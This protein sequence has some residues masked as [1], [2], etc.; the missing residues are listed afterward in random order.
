MRLDPITL[1]VINNRIREIVS[2]MEHLLFHGGYST[3]LRESFDGSAGICDREGLVVMG[4]GMPLHLFPYHYSVRAVLANY[5][6]QEMEDGD[7]FILTDPYRGGNLHLP[8]LVIITPIFVDGDVLGFGVSIA[9]KTDL[10]GIVPG[11]SGAASRE[12]FHEGLLL[13]GVKY[14]TKDGPVKEVDEIVRRNSRTPET[15]AGDIRAQIGCTRVGAQR[16]ADL[17]A[18]YGTGTIKAALEELLRSAEIRVRQGL[19]NWPDGESEAEAMVDN[20]AV[21]LDVPLRLHVR[22]V[23]KGDSITFDYSDTNNQVKGPI[24]LRPQCG[25]GGALLALMSYLDPSIPINDGTRR[26]VNFI[27]PEGKI[28]N[29]RWPAPV[30]NYF[31]LTHVLYSTVLKALATFN[32]S[33]AVGTAGLG[34]G[35]LAI[36]YRGADGSRQT[37]QY[38]LFPTSLGATPTHDGTS[39]VEPM[40]HFTPNTPVEILET[41]FSV[42]VLCHEWLPDTGGAGKFRGGPGF[43]KEYLMGQDALVTLRLGHMFEHTGW[44]VFGGCAPPPASACVNPGAPNQRNLRPL[45]TFDISKG[46]ILRVVMPGGGGYGEPKQREPD[47]VLKDVLNGWVSMEAARDVYGVVIDG[48]PLQ[49]N[50]EQTDA[51]RISA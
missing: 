24:N 26:P 36:G 17:C 11:S 33:R 20:D 30:N 2:T 45:E 1:E 25:E 44:G 42:R 51:L 32:P 13:P 22:V 10:G 34:C 43:R 27:N 12:M 23:K 38:E 14:W 46:E 41:E 8:D 5:A 37:V 35:A 29:P 47:L 3:I 49:V 48:E 50:R 21:D 18:E 9:H 28:T 40:S 19:S 39:P 4:S 6:H 15:V 31:G 7:S 16:V